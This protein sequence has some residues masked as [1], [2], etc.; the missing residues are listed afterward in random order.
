MPRKF[1][2]PSDTENAF[3]DALERGD[4]DVMKDVWCDSDAV[5]CIHPGALRLVGRDQVVDSFSLM[6]EDAPAMDFSITDSKCQTLENIAIHH[7]REE[8]ELDGQLVTVMVSTNIYQLVDGG[9]RMML[10]HASLE[11]DQE[12]DELDYTLETESP[13]VLH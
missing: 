13:I 8:I 10:H 6:F 9:W 1:L 3:Y 7:V 4:I 12:F 11:P 2:T 5:V